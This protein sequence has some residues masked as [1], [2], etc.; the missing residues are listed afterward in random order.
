MAVERTLFYMP[1]C[2]LALY[3]NLIRV[4]VENIKN[5]V[6]LG[7]DFS[8]YF[9]RSTD[10]K[11][12]KDAFYVSRMHKIN[13]TIQQTNIL[14]DYGSFED[15]TLQMTDTNFCSSSYWSPPHG[16]EC[17]NLNELL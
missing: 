1:H 4:N 3:D 8:L 9:L 6:I 15:L 7:N 16:Y 2:P 14:S 10:K 11:F 13:S 17:R 12:E 5:V